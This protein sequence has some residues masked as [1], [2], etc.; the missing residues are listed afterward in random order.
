MLK[1]KRRK[2]WVGFDRNTYFYLWPVEWELWCL[3]GRRQQ[4]W[5]MVCN[6]YLLKGVATPNQSVGIFCW[7]WAG[8]QGFSRNSKPCLTSLFKRQGQFLLNI[9]RSLAGLSWGW[10]IMALLAGSNGE[11]AMHLSI[12]FSVVRP[13]AWSALPDHVKNAPSLNRFKY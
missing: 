9:H 3:T 5:W 12:A 13:T 4:N 11:P 10:C 1:K 8:C 2:R 7:F 6:F